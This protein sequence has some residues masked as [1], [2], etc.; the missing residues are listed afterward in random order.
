MKGITWSRDSHGLFDYESRHLTKRT[1]KA[2]DQMKIVRNGNDLEIVPNL[3]KEADTADGV[4]KTSLLK[5]V[6]NGSKFSSKISAAI[7]W[8]LQFD[9]LSQFPSDLIINLRVNR[10]NLFGGLREGR[11]EQPE[12]QR[13]DVPRYA[14]VEVR[15]WENRKLLTWLTKFQLLGLWD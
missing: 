11:C 10:S 4:E 7:V 1:M 8:L 6:Q 15:K 2:Q 12:Q 13:P 14:V 9:L 5:I 3:D